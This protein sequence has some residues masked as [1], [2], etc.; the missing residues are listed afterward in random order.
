[1]LLLT[2]EQPKHR[3]HRG[4]LYIRVLSLSSVACTTQET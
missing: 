2:G 1:M 3:L 4:T